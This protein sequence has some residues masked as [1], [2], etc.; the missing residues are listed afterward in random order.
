MR[1]SCKILKR[2]IRES[3]K[4]KKNS[5]A[6]TGRCSGRSRIICGFSLAEMEKARLAFS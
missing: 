4:G 1:N 5:G 6:Y 2:G 3:A